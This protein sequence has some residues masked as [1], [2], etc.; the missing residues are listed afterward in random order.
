MINLLR[1]MAL[2]L[3]LFF[4]SC[5]GGG[6]GGGG[7]T[8]PPPCPNF[9]GA[10]SWQITAECCS[11]GICLPFVFCAP[12]SIVST[13]EGTLGMDWG[14]SV[15][16]ATVD[17]PGNF[18]AT[19]FDL[20]NS[21]DAITPCNDPSA[22]TWSEVLTMDGNLSAMSGSLVMGY[23]EHDSMGITVFEIACAGTWVRVV[24]CP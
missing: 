24:A 3:Y 19:L 8:A 10:Y 20:G 7:G 23:E 11:Q 2:A 5:G 12:V 21:C 1:G 22:V 18:T 6:G 4:I 16:S 14:G 17:C 15:G 13:G 9:A